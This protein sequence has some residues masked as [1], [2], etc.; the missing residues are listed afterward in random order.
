M[1]LK[2]LVENIQ[3]LYGKL[4]W[5]SYKNVGILSPLLVAFAHDGSM[6]FALCVYYVAPFTAIIHLYLC[7]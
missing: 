4:T 3:K 5:K 2:K 7:V 6:F 1:T